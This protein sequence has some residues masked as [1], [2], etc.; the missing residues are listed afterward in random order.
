VHRASAE[1]FQRLTHRVIQMA[2]ADRKEPKADDDAEQF[3]R[4]LE[5][6]RKRRLDESLEDFA[7][8]FFEDGA[9][10]N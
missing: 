3:Q 6:A 5:G 4:F 9:P 8:K 7:V 2:K 10:P 1:R